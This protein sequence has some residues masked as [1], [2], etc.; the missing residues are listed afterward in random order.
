MARKHRNHAE[1]LDIL[2]TEVED[3]DEYKPIKEKFTVT[4]TFIVKSDDIS[5]AEDAVSDMITEAVASMAGEYEPETVI[6]D[7]YLDIDPAEIA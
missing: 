4:A 7:Y 5:L 3:G 6:V 1:D 2:E